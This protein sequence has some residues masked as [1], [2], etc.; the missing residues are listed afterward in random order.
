MYM[1]YSLP[2]GRF[3]CIHSGTEGTPIMITESPLKLKDV[4]QHLDRYPC[5]NIHVFIIV[6]VKRR[7]AVNNVDACT[8]TC[9][10]PYL[11]AGSF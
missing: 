7:C 4:S 11:K 6:F 3:I 9:S 5:Y 1:Q 8:C 2:Q 10:V